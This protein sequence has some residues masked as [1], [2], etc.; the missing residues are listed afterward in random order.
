MLNKNTVL[1]FLLLFSF[2]FAI[3]QTEPPSDLEGTALRTWL[4]DN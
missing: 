4:K 3:G 2:R 1:S